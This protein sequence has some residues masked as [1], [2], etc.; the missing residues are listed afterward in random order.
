MSSKAYKNLNVKHIIKLKR[1]KTVYQKLINLKF[2]FNA[3]LTFFSSLINLQKFFK[4]HH[5]S[6]VD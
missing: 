2:F 1:A 5:T 4:L 6:L 3:T